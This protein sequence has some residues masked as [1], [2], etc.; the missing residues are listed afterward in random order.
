MPP[1][2]RPSIRPCSA[3]RSRSWGTGLLRNFLERECGCQPTWTMSAFAE[4]AVAEIRATVGTGRVVC[5]LS[6]GVDSAVVAALVHR[7]IGAQLT[8]IFV[9]HGLLRQG[10][11]E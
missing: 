8:C 9:D 11:A 2:R 10:E 1:A 4:R 7:A 5:G 6:G 3:R